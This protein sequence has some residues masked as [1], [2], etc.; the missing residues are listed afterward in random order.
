MR[1][2]FAVI[3]S[4]DKVAALGWA[5]RKAL[6]LIVATASPDWTP[7]GQLADALG[8]EAVDQEPIYHEA[9]EKRVAA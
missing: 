4:S 2:P 6:V 5:E 1:D 3:A 7:A 9:A 8:I